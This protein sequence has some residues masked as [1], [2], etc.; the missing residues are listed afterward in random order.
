M[1][2]HQ[3]IESSAE[4]AHNPHDE[5]HKGEFVTTQQDY[6][7]PFTGGLI[8]GY[9]VRPSRK[10]ANPV[11]AGVF[12]LGTSLFT[13]GLILAGT[14]NVSSPAVL[15]GSFLFSSGLIQI[16]C[17]IWSIVLENVFGSVLLL[18]YGGFFASFGAIQNGMGVDAYTDADELTNALGLYVAAWTVFAIVLWTATFKST[19]PLFLLTFFTAM[20]FLL[21]DIAIFGNHTGCETASGVFC[22]LAAMCAFYAGYVGMTKNQR[23]SYIPV[24]KTKWL[25]MPSSARSPD[26]NQAGFYV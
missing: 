5:I 3:D 12:S 7:A 10:F 16:I 20:F 4:T 21:Y 9:Q 2:T 11:P 14:R 22:F 23:N 13:L 19:L 15:T 25:L 24:P 26:Y 8:S 6:L 18:C 1:S 17:G